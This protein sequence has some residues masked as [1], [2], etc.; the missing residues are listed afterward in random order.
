MLQ[1]N[2]TAVLVLHIRRCVLNVAIVSHYVN[3][4]ILL[5]RY[6]M[7]IV[8]HTWTIKG[9]VTFSRTVRSLLPSGQGSGPKGLTLPTKLHTATMDMALL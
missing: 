7:A 1:D 5:T 6:G 4:P 2:L 8:V 9:V 3:Q